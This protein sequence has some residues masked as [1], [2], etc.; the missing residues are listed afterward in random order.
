MV[1]LVSSVNAFAGA[2][3]AEMF[4]FQALILIILMFAF[5]AFAASLFLLKIRQDSNISKSEINNLV[6]NDE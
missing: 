2:M 5:M 3:V 1:F 6:Q 4:G